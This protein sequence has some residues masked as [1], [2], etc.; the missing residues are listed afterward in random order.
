MSN[1]LTEEEWQ[2]LKDAWPIWDRI[3]YKAMEISDKALM[4][5]GTYGYGNHDFIDGIDDTG[6][7][8]I[9]IEAHDDGEWDTTTQL[10]TPEQ[11][12]DTD[13]VE[14]RFDLVAKI[15]NDARSEAALKQSI[16][17]RRKAYEALRKE[18]EEAG[19]P[20]TGVAYYEPHPYGGVTK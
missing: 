19:E 16:E 6:I 12:L 1:L 3:K 20:A 11:L 15:V 5:S 17:M 13:A 9:G 4:A 10:I 18:F 7:T 14:L 8:V 2:Q